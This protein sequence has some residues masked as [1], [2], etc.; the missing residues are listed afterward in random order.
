V[1]VYAGW[2]GPSPLDSD[3]FARVVWLPLAGPF[4][5]GGPFVG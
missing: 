5:V 1:T 4:P 3:E 2:L